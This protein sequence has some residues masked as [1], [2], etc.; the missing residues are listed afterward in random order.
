MVPHG[1][2]VASFSEKYVKDFPQNTQPNPLTIC[3]P[4]ERPC[5]RHRP[6]PPAESPNGRP[7]C[8]PK[9]S[10]S[11]LVHFFAGTSAIP[12]L[13]L[14]PPSRRAWKGI[15]R[16]SPFE[17]SI[18]P[19]TR[20]HPSRPVLSSNRHIARWPTDLCSSEL[21]WRGCSSLCLAAARHR[22]QSFELSQPTDGRLA[23]REASA[24]CDG[25]NL[26]GEVVGR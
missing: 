8:F 17:S 7:T 24:K 16:T 18:V 10:T 9:S 11:H 26:C 3:F 19:R 22:L 15:L 4:H 2:D 21:L 12:S 14:S 20:W 13:R 6:Q 5:Q 1:C 23:P 25:L